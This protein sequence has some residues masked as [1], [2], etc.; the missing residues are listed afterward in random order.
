[1]A[2]CLNLA[3][4]LVAGREVPVEGDA[5]GVVDEPIDHDRAPRRVLSDGCRETAR[6]EAAAPERRILALEGLE[7]AFCPSAAAILPRRPLTPKLLDVCVN[8]WHE[9]DG[10][11]VAGQEAPGRQLAEKVLHLT[12]SRSRLVFAPRPADD[13]MQR[14][15]DIGRARELLGWEPAITLD[16]GLQRTVRYFRDLLR[17]T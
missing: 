13:P 1:M 6:R 15:P 9:P 16:Q 11:T 10:E 14:R 17:A 12:D 2:K 7:V 3:R 5:F 8:K 4:G